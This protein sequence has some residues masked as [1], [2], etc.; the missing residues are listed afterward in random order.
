MIK[1]ITLYLVIFIA[2]FLL[3]MFIYRF[4][5]EFDN[6][7][8]KAYLREEADKFGESSE[9]VYKLLH[10]SVQDTLKNSDEVQQIRIYS[11]AN[12]IP[13]ERVLVDTAIIKAQNNQY[14]N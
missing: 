2:V 3:S 14:I 4:Y 5:F 6:S 1:K 13:K 11:R 10:E 7:K 12:K 8:V 9:A